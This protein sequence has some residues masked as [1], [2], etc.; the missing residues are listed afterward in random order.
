MRTWKPA[1]MIA[2]LLTGALPR[3]IAAPATTTVADDA[4]ASAS[5]S[6]THFMSAAGDEE[7]T[8][9]TQARFRHGLQKTQAEGKGD[10]KS[11]QQIALMSEALKEFDLRAAR[12]VE[13]AVKAEKELGE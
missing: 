8:L 2:L 6:L 1:V 12:A 4:S 10:P 13:A 3:A 5:R 7:A 11:E 9:W